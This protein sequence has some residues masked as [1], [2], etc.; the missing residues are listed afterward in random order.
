[1]S[2]SI[3]SRVA[4]IGAHARL[5]RDGGAA[6]SAPARKAADLALNKRLIER[7]SLDESAPD[8][9]DRLKHARSAHFK[10]LRLK[11]AGK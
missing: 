6:V 11:G 5:A 1:V 3:R 7:Y 4:S 9:H 8:F 10:A 2:L